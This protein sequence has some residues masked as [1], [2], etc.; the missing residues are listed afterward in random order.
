MS[1]SFCAVSVVPA[2][3]APLPLGRFLVVPVIPHASSLSCYL[4]CWKRAAR[5][6]PRSRCSPLSLGAAVALPCQYCKPL[7]ASASCCLTDSYSLGSIWCGRSAAAPCCGVTSVGSGIHPLI[8]QKPA[9]FSFSRA[10]LAD[11]TP[12]GSNRARSRVHTSFRCGQIQ[13][14][15]ALDLRPA[16]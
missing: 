8:R 3:L 6:L 7:C 16:S 12:S 1:F 11:Y 15:V 2:A 9:G 5:S 10:A 13:A 4:F 14:L